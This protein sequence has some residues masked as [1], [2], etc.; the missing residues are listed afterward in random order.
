MAHNYFF[1]WNIFLSQYCLSNCQIVCQTN[2][3]IVIK[4]YCDKKIF[5]SHGF[6]WQPREA[7]VKTQHTLC[8]VLF[9]AY[10]GCS[11]ELYWLIS[12]YL[13]IA[14]L[15]AEMSRVNWALGLTFQLFVVCLWKMNCWEKTY[16]LFFEKS[17]AK[18]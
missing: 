2:H 5:L 10:L 11:I 7:I 8:C 15:C 1:Y 12:K 14:I 13:F 17:Y 9:R 4:R 3:N 18:N 16:I 6:Q